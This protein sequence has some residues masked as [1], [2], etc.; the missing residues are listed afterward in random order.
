MKLT[1]E[2]AEF[3]AR[4]PGEYHIVRNVPQALEAAL[5]KKALS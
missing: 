1:K 4:W 5:G 3:M 2:Q